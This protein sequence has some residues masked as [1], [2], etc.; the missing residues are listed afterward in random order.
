MQI[1][2]HEAILK[3]QTWCPPSTGWVKINFDAHLGT[4]PI[5]GLGVVIRDDNGKLLLAGVRRVCANW[6]VDMSEATT[7]KFGVEL[8]ARF[9]YQWVHL[10]GDS[11][12]VV[13][14][15]ENREAGL[16]PIHLFYDDIFRLYSSFNDFGCS[17]V[18][19]NRNILAH[20]VTRWELG[21]PSEKICMDPFPQS[22]LALANLDI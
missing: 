4:G 5:R 18:S 3:F 10:E 6:S 9:G 8:A 22:L 2:N 15:I 12:T 17:F 11:L 1:S 21:N 16:S 20:L 14:A 19:R 13:R 7:A